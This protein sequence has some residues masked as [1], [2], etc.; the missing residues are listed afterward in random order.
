MLQ[1]RNDYDKEVFNGDLGVIQRIDAKA[2]TAIVS[3]GADFKEVSYTKGELRDLIPAYAMTIHK[4]QGSE[5]RAVV[6][7]MTNA[8][9][10]L[11][12]RELL[13]TG[14]T[15]AKELLVIV[16][17]RT[18]L[19]AAIDTAG[20]DRR[21]TGLVDRLAAAPQPKAAATRAKGPR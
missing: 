7:V 18:A 13:Y 20:K 2:G 3:F 12:R 4:A 19:A 8:H 5:Y 1:Q 9:K 6:L 16:A 14:V 21:C 11:L 10:P 17:P 15:R